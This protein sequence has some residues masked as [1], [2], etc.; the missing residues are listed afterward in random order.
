MGIL[1]DTR[2]KGDFLEELNDELH[3]KGVKNPWEVNRL[4]QEETEKKR[5]NFKVKEQGVQ[6]WKMLC[7]IINQKPGFAVFKCV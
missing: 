5:E 2:P 1:T 3:L 4:E 6:K 7:L